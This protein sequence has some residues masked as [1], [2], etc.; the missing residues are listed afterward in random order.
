V[1]KAGIRNIAAWLQSLRSAGQP[2]AGLIASV[3]EIDRRVTYNRCVCMCNVG[4]HDE[5]SEGGSVWTWS[6]ESRKR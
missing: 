3:L 1:L 2:Q 4:H 6:L 5:H